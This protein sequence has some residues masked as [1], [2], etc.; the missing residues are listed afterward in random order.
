MEVRP[1]TSDEKLWIEYQGCIYRL[2]EQIAVYSFFERLRSG[3]LLSTGV[4]EAALATLKE[5]KI[6]PA[7]W[8][9]D[10]WVYLHPGEIR[11]LPP[12]KLRE[13][14]RFWSS[15]RV[16]PRELGDAKLEPEDVTSTGGAGRWTSMD[17]IEPEFRRRV[18]EGKIESTLSAEA[19]WLKTWYQQKYPRLLQPTAKTIENHFRADYR[20]AMN[21]LGSS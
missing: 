19:E 1:P 9:R 17:I 16:S 15:I 8:K 21:K 10:I 2:S 13:G 14:K 11:E 20:Q 3:Q 18:E 4:A 12:T 5:R 6:P 7:W